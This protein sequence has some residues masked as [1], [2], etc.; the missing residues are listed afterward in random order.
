[1]R[2]HEVS[3]FLIQPEYAYGEHGCPPRIPPN[4]ILIFDVEVMH[5]VEQEG[6]DDYYSLTPEERKAKLKYSDIEK[7]VKAENNV[8]HYLCVH[9]LIFIGLALS[10]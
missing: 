3:R 7:V 4:A 6:V 8:S 9:I 5:F 1:M 2:K 10:L